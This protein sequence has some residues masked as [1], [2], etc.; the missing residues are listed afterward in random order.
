MYQFLV[1]MRMWPSFECDHN[2]M[3]IW[4]NIIVSLLK[5]KNVKSI[6]IKLGKEHH[7]YSFTTIV[8]NKFLRKIE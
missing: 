4:V 6:Q 3:Y 5:C 8:C 1:D 7:E 2:V